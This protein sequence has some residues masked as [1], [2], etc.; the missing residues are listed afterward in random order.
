[1]CAWPM[2]SA[3]QGR[4]GVF[5]SQMWTCESTMMQPESSALAGSDGCAIARP[6]PAA[7]VVVTTSRREIMGTLL[8]LRHSDDALRARLLPLCVGV[9]TTPSCPRGSRGPLDPQ[10]R[11]TPDA[12]ACSATVLG[13]V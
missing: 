10:P 2:P 12:S 7:S 1:M 4:S 8:L 11:S 3:G 5:A 13:L 6:A 9:A